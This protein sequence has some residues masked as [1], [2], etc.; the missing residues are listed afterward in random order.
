M[1]LLR[2][3]LI[4]AAVGICMAVSTGPLAAQH[5]L[6][7]D[8]SKTNRSIFRPIAEWPDVNEFRNAAGAPGYAYWQQQADY[9]IRVA[10]HNAEAF[11]VLSIGGDF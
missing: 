9:E 2:H 8:G 1:A 10:P 5:W 11:N 6:H 7:D 3:R 4:L